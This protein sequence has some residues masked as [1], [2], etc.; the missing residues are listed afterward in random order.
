MVASFDIFETKIIYI[1]HFN[2]A[3]C[4]LDYLITKQ[5]PYQNEISPE[6]DSNKYR[7]KLSASSSVV[8]RDA[9]IN[10][11]DEI[12]V[13]EHQREVN[14]FSGLLVRDALLV[15]HSF[16]NHRIKANV[17]HD[18]V[19]SSVTLFLESYILSPEGRFV[20][21]SRRKIRNCA[22]S[23][24]FS[25]LKRTVQRSDHDGQGLLSPSLFMVEF[26]RCL[27]A[28]LQQREPINSHRI[29]MFRNG[30]TCC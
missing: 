6:K 5:Q 30:R 13:F 9:W 8:T 1:H 19:C 3:V 18:A 21:F 29:Y 25:R 23:C 12:S 15:N 10:S 20:G 17:I 7:C 28:A 22:S 27:A 4:P 11:E 16:E 24:F 14:L 26:E 2:G